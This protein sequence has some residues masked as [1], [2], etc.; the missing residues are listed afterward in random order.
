MS[1]HGLMAIVVLCFPRIPA[2]IFVDLV[3]LALSDASVVVVEFL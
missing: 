3:E 1:C 2:D